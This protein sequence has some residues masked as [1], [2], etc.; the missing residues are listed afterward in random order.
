MAIGKFG[1]ILIGVY[2]ISHLQPIR[3]QMAMANELFVGEIF[4]A[5]KLIWVCFGLFCVQAILS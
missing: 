1:H 5:H 2:R 4:Y 3:L